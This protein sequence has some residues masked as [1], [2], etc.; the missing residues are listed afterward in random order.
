M[1]SS[2]SGSGFVSSRVPRGAGRSKGRN[3]VELVKC[4]V[5]TGK[6]VRFAARQVTAQL[7]AVHL[8]RLRSLSGSGSRRRAFTWTTWTGTPEDLYRL[9]RLDLLEARGTGVQLEARLT[10]LGR[11][12]ASLGESRP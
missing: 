4:N 1:P 2:V 12:V 10:W 9:V 6:Y 3:R 8:E 11:V 7:E 5:P